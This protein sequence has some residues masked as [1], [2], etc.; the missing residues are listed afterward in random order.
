[1][2]RRKRRHCRRFL[3]PSRLALGIKPSPFG[4]L[5]VLV[6]PAKAGTQRL[7]LLGLLFNQ[8]NKYCYL[9]VVMIPF[10]LSLLPGIL[11][12]EPSP[13]PSQSGKPLQ[14][15]ESLVSRRKMS[16]DVYSAYP[17]LPTK[18]QRKHLHNPKRQHQLVRNLDLVALSL[19][20]G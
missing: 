4:F 9:K 5:L 17:P 1:M 6:I 14:V 7:W 3:C 2:E 8:K 12:C 20:T 13:S 15:V 10:A 18:K 16:S 11:P 19:P